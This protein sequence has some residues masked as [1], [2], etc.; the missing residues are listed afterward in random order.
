MPVEHD[1]EAHRFTAS[2]ASGKAVL[3]YT[4]A[5]PGVLELYSTFVPPRR[6]REGHRGTAGRGRDGLRAERR[7]PDHSQLLVRRPMDRQH[8]EHADLLSA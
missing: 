4:P 3:A 1:T 5:G 7:P 2:V 8:P 6:S